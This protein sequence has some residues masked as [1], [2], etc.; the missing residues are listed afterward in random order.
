MKNDRINP[1]STVGA[2]HPDDISSVPK[3]VYVQAFST[4][5]ER[6]HPHAGSVT[7]SGHI[8]RCE[9]R[10]CTVN[11]RRRGTAPALHPIRRVHSDYTTRTEVGDIIAAVTALAWV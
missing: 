5:C 1:S 3:V 6:A 10:D 2:V 9:A 4:M 11:T 8:N 7:E